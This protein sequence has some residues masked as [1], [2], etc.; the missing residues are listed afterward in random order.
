ML[1][2]SIEHEERGKG[3]SEWSREQGVRP[4]V[5]S[6]IGMCTYSIALNLQD[7]MLCA[8]V[9]YFKYRMYMKGIDFMLHK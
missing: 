1:H 3:A 8:A 6:V 7:S 5:M 9:D 2:Q 4:G